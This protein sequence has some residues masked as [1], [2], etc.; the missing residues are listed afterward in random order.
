MSEM[1]EHRTFECHGELASQV[2]RWCSE[3]DGKYTVNAENMNR[4]ST[5]Y[6][7]FLQL[8]DEDGGEVAN[9]DA[10][11]ESAHANVTIEVSL[12]DLCKDSMRQFLDVLRGID[13]L[14]AKA[15]DSGSLLI[16][17]SVNDVWEV[18]V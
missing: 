3:F 2:E 17:A 10:S 4:F 11:P 1:K 12:I 9:L 6:D 13:V 16:S 7:Y 5:V 18:V 8:V 15:T 14:E